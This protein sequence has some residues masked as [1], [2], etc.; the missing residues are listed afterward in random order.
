MHYGLVSGALNSCQNF[1][2]LTDENPVCMRTDLS[3][4]LD[5]GAFLVGET[6]Q[7]CPFESS[8]RGDGGQSR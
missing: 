7:S 3:A 5:Y 4:C 2:R 6:L 1:N 8:D